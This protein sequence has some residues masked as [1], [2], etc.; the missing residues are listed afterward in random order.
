M[1]GEVIVAILNTLVQ[2]PDLP[3]GEYPS[4]LHTTEASLLCH[5]LAHTILHLPLMHSSTLP[6]LD[7]VPY[8]LTTRTDPC[9]HVPIMHLEEQSLM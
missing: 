6:C 9:V 5:E 4:S 8:L 1:F 7:I 3:N 2:I